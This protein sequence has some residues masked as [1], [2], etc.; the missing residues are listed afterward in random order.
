VNLDTA[1]T[2]RLDREL[3]EASDR[4]LPTRRAGLGIFRF[5]LRIAEVV[6]AS[7]SFGL[8]PL[9]GISLFGET[10]AGVAASAVAL[11]VFMLTPFWVGDRLRRAVYGRELR[12]LRA[13]ALTGGAGGAR[14]SAALPLGDERGVVDRLDRLD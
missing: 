3:R 13:P 4:M 8:G 5:W 6:S 14:S 11:G 10:L 2:R 12:R 7:F 9:V 1:T